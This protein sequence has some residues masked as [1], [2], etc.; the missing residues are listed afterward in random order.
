MRL[1]PEQIEQMTLPGLRTLIRN[2]TVSATTPLR[3]AGT[4]Q[5]TVA[6]DVD[7]FPQVSGARR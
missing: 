1:R 3:E 6:G 4:E 2:G 5:W 7:Q